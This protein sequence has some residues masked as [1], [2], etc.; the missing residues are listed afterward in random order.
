MSY[1]QYVTAGDHHHFEDPLPGL[2]RANCFTMAELEQNR[3][4][5][6]SDGQWMRLLFRALQPVKYTGGA[7][8]GWLFFCYLVKLIV[9][10]IILWIMAL[11]GYGVALFGGITLAC[12]GAFLVSVIKSA[13]TMS[14]LI[15]DLSAGKAACTEG[16]VS[17]SREEEHGLGTARFW[18]EKNTNYWYVVKNEYFEVDPEAH[19][20]LPDAMQGRLYHTPKSKMLLS[21]EPQS[22]KGSPVTQGTT[23]AA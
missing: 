2:A 1:I 15:V 4:G 16:R 6:I 9:P 22:P 18:G 7:L 17:P 12:V 19:R 11:K 23:Q 20:V 3:Q 5:K 13:H 14:L 21:I 8:A 10:S